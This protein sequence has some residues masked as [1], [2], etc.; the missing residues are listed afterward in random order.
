MQHTLIAVFDNRA[1]AQGAMDELLLSGF[2]RENVRMSEDTSA[3]GDYADADRTE[4]EGIG[5]SIKHFFSDLFGSDN[6]FRSDKYSTAISKGHHLVTVSALDD[7]AVERAADVIERFNPVDIDEKAA[8][9]GVPST[10]S[11]GAMRMGSTG[12]MQRSQGTSLQF[13]GDRN[14]FAQQSL[15]DER[16]MGQTYQEPMGTNGEL[17]VGSFGN[18]HGESLSG[19]LQQDTSASG[20][21]GMASRREV[22]R[23][24]VR[25][26]S[27]LGADRPNLDED[28]YVSH[29][30]RTYS[31]TGDSF[32]DYAPAYSY[33]HEVAM[34][35]RGRPW[36]DVEYDVR[37]GWESRQASAGE[38]TWDRFKDAIRHGWN[39]LT[40]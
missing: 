6:D 13:E 36:E 15:N 16:P 34:M 38:S 5:A 25:V 8:E 20:D 2:S 40:H 7:T 22:R 14:L 21:S 18:P 39:R 37:S 1:D 10:P 3:T 26:F 27:P 9:W 28:Y 32:D 33:G 17:S 30:E 31:A 24:G 19:S 11:A 4:D 23:G 35:Y 29:W 12:A